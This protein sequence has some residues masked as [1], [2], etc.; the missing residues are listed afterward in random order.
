MHSRRSRL[1]WILL[2]V[3]GVLLVV[4]VV[5]GVI[6]VVLRQQRGA[7]S[8][9]QDPMAALLPEEIAPDLA[10]YPLAG[11]SQLDTI[12]AAIANGDL[13]LAY[14]AIAFSVDVPDSQRMGRL[15]LLGRRFEEAEKPDRAGLCYRQIYDM[16]ILSPWLNDPARADACLASAQGW[17]ALGQKA[18]ALSVYDQVYR[19]AVHSPYL[20]RANRRDLLVVLE[21]AYR[22]LGDAEQANVC[23][24]KI[25]EL[26]QE[27]RPQP[28]AA[29]A[30]SPDLPKGDEAV[31]SP[32]VG[33]LE[34]TRRQEAFILL[35]ALAA[36][37]EPSPG[38]VSGLAEALQE[39]DAA[40]L[41]LYRQELQATTQ[42]G[43]RID[44]Q[45]QII[46]WLMLKYQVAARGLG[47]SLL[48]DWE[49]QLA[50]I[51]SDL[52]KAYEELF[53]DYEDVVAASPD[54]TLM[55]PG[56][57]QVR[58]EMLLAGRLGRY[59]NYPVSQLADKLADAVANL[60][61]S[62]SV[63]RLYVDVSM[64]DEELRLFLSPAEEYGLSSQSP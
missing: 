35:E 1:V 61:A 31:S 29:P 55:G 15:I 10:L 24:E 37:K 45:W 39:E 43:R 2:A 62:G 34:E 7:S 28:V 9:W 20:Q 3:V 36:G 51:Q 41:A 27:S 13:E 6:Y 60:I 42:P 23:R 30:Q 58:R 54:A 19:I 11:A 5:S 44:V 57:Y 22:E 56:S 32:E 46:R 18:Q 8:S 63:D 26:D 48:P 52:S 47:L 21:G 49:A 53:F 64:E 4:A 14:A 17:A 59:A 50:D 40:K 12:D 38:L 16:A 33:A 25:I